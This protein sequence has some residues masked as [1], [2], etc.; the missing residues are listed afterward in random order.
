MTYNPENKGLKFLAFGAFWL[1]SKTVRAEVGMHVHAVCISSPLM[2]LPTS[3]A[4]LL[5]IMYLLAF[6]IFW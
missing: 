4:P 1:M 3:A 6:I 5:D 2:H